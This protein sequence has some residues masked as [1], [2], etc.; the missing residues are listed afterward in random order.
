MIKNET[1][2]NEQNDAVMWW[3]IYST[4]FIA[5]ER[6]NVPELANIWKLPLKIF[7]NIKTF[8]LEIITVTIFTIF[9]S[10]FYSVLKCIFRLFAMGIHIPWKHLY[11]IIENMYQY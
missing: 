6:I 11:I 5:V 8:G 3:Q 10:L 7:T 2:Q 9:E 4:S 1:A